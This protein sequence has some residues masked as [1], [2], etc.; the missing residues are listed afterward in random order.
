MKSWQIKSDRSKRC[1]RQEYYILLTHEIGFKDKL[2][3]SPFHTLDV[4]VFE[5]ETTSEMSS[6]YYPVGYKKKYSIYARE[7]SL[8][9]KYEVNTGQ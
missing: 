1:L 9:Y 7:C 6:T 2:Y 5:T 3:M 8:N 4:L